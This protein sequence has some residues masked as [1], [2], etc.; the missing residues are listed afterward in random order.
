[1][2]VHPS[3]CVKQGFLTSAVLCTYAWYRCLPKH[4]CTCYCLVNW[5]ILLPSDKCVSMGVGTCGVESKSKGI[6]SLNYINLV[7]VVICRLRTGLAVRLEHYIYFPFEI[8]GTY[9]F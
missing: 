2:R 1:M 5:D 6:W 4:V 8:L 7:T 3:M 9:D